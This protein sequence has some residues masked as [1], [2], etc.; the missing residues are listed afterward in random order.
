MLAED[1]NE[2]IYSLQDFINAESSQLS[3]NGS[4]G[5]GGF[6][7]HYKIDLHV[8]CDGFKTNLMPKN[9]RRV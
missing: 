6:G 2:Y 9:E 1:G 4:G 5:K 8:E 3:V 7:N